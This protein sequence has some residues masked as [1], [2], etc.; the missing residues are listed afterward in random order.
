MRNKMAAGPAEKNTCISMKILIFLL[1]IFFVASCFAQRSDFIVL[2]KKNNRTL[3]SYYEGSYLR[4]ETFSGFPISG[5]IKKIANDSITIA[6]QQVQQVANQFGLPSLDTM[7]YTLRIHFADI[8]RYDYKSK[9]RKKGFSRITIPGILTRAGFGFA[10]LETVNT[11]YRKE[12]FSS[13]DKLVS[14]GTG[15]AVGGAGI[16]WHEIAKSRSKAGAKYIVHYI[17]ND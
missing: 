12:S 6:Q 4:G 14:I 7:V 8:S 16:L 13:N 10:V 17:K 9:N 11:I 1:P 5:M 2:K 15:L 3:K